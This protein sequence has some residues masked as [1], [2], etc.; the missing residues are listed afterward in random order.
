MNRP[1][2]PRLFEVEALRDGRLTGAERGSFERHVATC[3]ACAHEAA[4]LAALGEALRTTACDEVDELKLRRERTRLLADFDRALVRPRRPW[5]ARGMLAASVMALSLIAGA[6]LLWQPGGR[7]RTPGTALEA[8]I[9]AD[10]TARWTR[11]A[12]ADR[13]LVVLDHGE[14]RIRTQQTPG[15][16]RFAV[17][18][19]DGELED[20]GTVFSVAVL[21]GR[22]ERVHVDD[23][24]VLLKLHGR[25]PVLLRAGQTWQAQAPAP[26][27]AASASDAAPKP[28][29]RPETA[30]PSETAPDPT[31]AAVP[32]V[33]SARA[34]AVESAPSSSATEPEASGARSAAGASEDFRAA[35]AAFNAGQPAVAAQRFQRFS[36]RHVADPRA[37]DAAYLRV[38]ALERAGDVEGRRAAARA[39]LQRYPAGFRRAEVERLAR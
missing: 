6:I 25:A 28:A 14:L 3:G 19:P 27:S 37:E 33:S 21:K 5:L 23:G 7:G 31:R 16:P 26:R 4:A 35:L 20:I 13:E 36:E 12:H 1:T 9:E 24:S 10:A 18:L 22:T 34:R 39:Y 30:P 2:C 15:K 32:P 17:V 8:V 38:L 11:R 29:P